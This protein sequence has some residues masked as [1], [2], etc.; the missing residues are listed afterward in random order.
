MYFLQ[1]AV[2]LQII[3]ISPEFYTRMLCY[4]LLELENDLG[5]V[6]ISLFFINDL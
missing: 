4:S 1:P 5:E 2:V 3:S 6:E